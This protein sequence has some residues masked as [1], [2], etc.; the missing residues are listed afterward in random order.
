MTIDFTFF[1]VGDDLT[2]PKML[3]ES[4]KATNPN[5]N[6]IQLTDKRTPILS[7]LVTKFLRIDGNKDNLMFLRSKAYQAYKI[8]NPTLFVDTDMLV[9]KEINVNQ[10]FENKKYIFLERY[11]DGQI[12]PEYLKHH[13]LEQYNGKTWKEFCPYLGCFIGAKDQKLLKEIHKNYN[14]LDH[15]YRKWNGDQMA[16]IE[17]FKN[18]NE[19]NLVSEK[20]YANP[21]KDDVE[22]NNI[23]ILHFKGAL[24]N[25]MKIYFDKMFNN[26]K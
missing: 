24:K 19:I 9:I 4:I 1:H 10:I 25:Q 11:Y 18:S 2:L 3:C 14:N 7:E 15:H 13:K 5:S 20:F 6:I 17:T 21:L 16:L 23:F 8:E 22:F 12:N 26:K